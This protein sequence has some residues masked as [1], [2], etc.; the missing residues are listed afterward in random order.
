MSAVYCCAAAGRIKQKKEKE[1]KTQTSKVVPTGLQSGESFG[2]QKAAGCQGN[3][4]LGRWETKSKKKKK[5]KG[6]KMMMKRVCWAVL[7]F[8]GTAQQQLTKRKR[9]PPALLFVLRDEYHLTPFENH[10]NIS[11]H[12]R[13]AGPAKICRPTNQPN[14]KRKRKRKDKTDRFE[15]RR[16]VCRRSTTSPTQRPTPTSDRRSRPSP[17]LLFRRE[18]IKTHNTK[19]DTHT[20]LSFHFGIQRPDT[21]T[22]I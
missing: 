13:A 5:K 10:N 12:R 18:N 19:R 11:Q 2:N 6:D 21:T 14:N 15:R 22:T 3:Q 17:L 8:D 4:N 1:K 16:T 9:S 7:L 20:F